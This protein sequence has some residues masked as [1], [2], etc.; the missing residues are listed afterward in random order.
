MVGSG[1][2]KTFGGAARWK[3]Q[4]I[5]A[6]MALADE[7][8]EKGYTSEGERRLGEDALTARSRH[9]ALQWAILLALD[10][11]KAKR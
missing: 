6:L 3:D 1:T 9:D 11:A 7:L 10:E 8:A 4:A 5:E 2:M